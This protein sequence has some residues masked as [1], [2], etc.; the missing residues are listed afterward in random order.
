MSFVNRRRFLQTAASAAT[1]GVTSTGAVRGVSIVADPAD[2][3]ASAG[4]AQWAA[5]ELERSLAATGVAVQR[6]ARIAEAK[7]GNQCIVAAGSSSPI[8]TEILKQAGVSVAAAPESLGLV[9]GTLAGRP[10][11]LACGHDTRGLVYAL[12]DLADRERNDA[13]TDPKGGGRTARQFRPR[14]LQTVLQ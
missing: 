13:P 10:V 8:A 9:P 12:L 6:C 14:N 2:P 4:P 3:V 1:F 5:S 11:L 7:A